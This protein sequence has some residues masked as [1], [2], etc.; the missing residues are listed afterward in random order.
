[1]A[2]RVVVRGVLLGV[3]ELVRVVQL[4]ER[5]RAHLVDDGR[6]EVDEDR[7]RHVLAGAGLAEERVERVVALADGGVRGHHAV[8]ADAVLEAE[9]LPDGVAGLDTGL[10]N[11]DADALSHCEDKISVLLC[12]ALGWKYPKQYFLTA[13]FFFKI[14][15]ITF[16]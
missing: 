8:G 10:P 1:M 2:A 5:A 9:E 13:T 11:V 15:D 7:A 14:D 6:L 12:V 4:L 3:D 16:F